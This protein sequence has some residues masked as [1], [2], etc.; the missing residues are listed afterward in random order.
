MAMLIR[1]LATK[2]VA[3][4]FLGRESNFSINTI[5]LEAASPSACL[6]SVEV[7]E[8]KA[9][10]APEISAE[11]NSKTNT[12][13]ILNACVVVINEMKSKL[14]GSI[15]KIVL[16]VPH[17]KGRSSSSMSITSGSFWFFT[18][19]EVCGALEVPRSVS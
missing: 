4:N 17:Q 3:S 15:S 7:N 11:Q 14:G 18:G 6:R 1:L 13:K 19:D 16:L 9:I 5:F 10:S 2:M 12:K 8:K